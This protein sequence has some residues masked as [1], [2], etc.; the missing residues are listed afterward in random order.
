[1][2]L[3]AI[4]HPEHQE[5]GI[6]RRGG[7]QQGVVVRFCERGDPLAE[8]VQRRLEIAPRI[9][10]DARAN[11]VVGRVREQPRPV[12]APDRLDRE[13]ELGFGQRR[14]HVLGMR[15]QVEQLGAP[16]DR[17]LAHDRDL[18]V[19]R[20]AAERRGR[21]AAV[22]AREREHVAHRVGEIREVRAGG[23]PRPT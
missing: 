2:H 16:R 13:H 17:R 12:G 20:E 14:D 23:H 19:D 9:E 5:L 3:D 10:I 8:R 4:L 11:L 21:G 6:E 7:A 18:L 22:L 1:V 15:H